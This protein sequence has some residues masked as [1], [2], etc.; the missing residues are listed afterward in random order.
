MIGSDINKESVVKNNK[1]TFET[2]PN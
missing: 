1:C 2:E